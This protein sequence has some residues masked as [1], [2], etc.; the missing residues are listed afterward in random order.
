[1]TTAHP[2]VRLLPRIA[3]LAGFSLFFAQLGAVGHAYSHDSGLERVAAHQPQSNSHEICA[4]CL[5]FSPLLLGAAAPPPMP[6]P[7]AAGGSTVSP[8]TGR[9]LVDRSTHLAF[10]SRAPPTL[11]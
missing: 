7:I 2:S 11:V 4:D 10:R 6:A 1:M 3:L 8:A 5:G 9:A